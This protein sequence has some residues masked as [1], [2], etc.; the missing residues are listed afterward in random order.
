VEFKTAG[1]SDA[2][3]K[4]NSITL[5]KPATRFHAVSRD[6][7]CLLIVSFID[8]DIIAVMVFGD[9]KP[10]GFYHPASDTK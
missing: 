5:K 8:Q 2:F 3:S 1:F 4:P 7:S 10:K 9:I 6:F